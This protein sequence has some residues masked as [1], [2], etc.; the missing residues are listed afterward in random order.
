TSKSWPPANIFVNGLVLSS[1]LTTMCCGFSQW[2]LN[3]P[4]IMLSQSGQL[5]RPLSRP[6]V[7]TYWLADV[8]TGTTPFTN[9]ACTT[10]PALPGSSCL[11]QAALTASMSGFVSVRS[12]ACSFFSLSPHDHR[13]ITDASVPPGPLALPRP[14]PRP[15]PAAGSSFGHAE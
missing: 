12:F 9:A 7:P 10:L 8:A 3:Q 6:A 5:P 14:K 2:N 1:I 11:Y 4:P 13:R 15:P